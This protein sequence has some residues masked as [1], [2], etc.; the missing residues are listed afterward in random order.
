MALAYVAVTAGIA[1]AATPPLPPAL[2]QAEAARERGDCLQASLL[3]AHAAET[4]RDVAIARRAADLS[5]ACDVPEAQWR[6][7]KRWRQLDPENIE[8]LRVYGITA[9]EQHRL[10]E[11]REVFSSLFNR[12]DVE[13][14]RALDDLL[15]EI[16]EQDAEQAAWAVFRTVIDR[17]RISPD[18]RIALARLAAAAFDYD[19][20]RAMLQPALAAEPDSAPGQRLA[21]RLA[22]ADGQTDEALRYAARAAEIDPNE[23]AFARAETLSDLDRIE[24]AQRE[25]ERLSQISATHDEAQRRLALLALGQ[26]DYDDARRR[27]GEIVS[28]GGATSV[29]AYF[30]LATIAELTGDKDTALANYQRLVKAGG[31]LLPRTRAAAL[32]LER[33]DAAAAARLFDEYRVASPQEG[34]SVAITRAGLLADAKRYD[35]ALA[36][37]TATLR[38]HPGDSKLRY[39]RAMTFER[40]GHTSEAI[41]EFEALLASRPDD[42]SILN[43]LGYTLI[44]QKRELARAENLIRRAVAIMPDNPALIDSL[45]WAMFRRGDA[46][47][48]LPQLERAWKLSYDDE[49]AA[50]W[51]EVLWVTGD[52]AQARAIWARALVRNPRGTVVS[53]AMRRLGAVPPT[54]VPTRATSEPTKPSAPPVPAAPAKPEGQ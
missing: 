9:L 31:G 11:A 39:E 28:R 44:D 6:A 26:A 51:G 27:F 12:P 48:A 29:E 17:K 23:S 37:L 3:Y 18:S 1:D 38:E 13:I 20:A 8:S 54:P 2:A 15:P 35:E 36:V 40:A 46:K 21:A 19:G 45:G 42:P 14:D 43:S 47:G 41:R 52:Q 33:G 50:H 16:S 49:I 24:E 34:V 22:A 4:L 32:L 7:A 53:T 30:Y 5:A 10:A 25:L